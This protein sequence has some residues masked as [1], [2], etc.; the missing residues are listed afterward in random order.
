M[1]IIKE[2]FLFHLLCDALGST[3]VFIKYIMMAMVEIYNDS[4]EVKFPFA[5]CK[6][7]FLILI[8]DFSKQG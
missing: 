5:N 7:Y 1:G 4:T 3:V 2:W 8:V 6:Y